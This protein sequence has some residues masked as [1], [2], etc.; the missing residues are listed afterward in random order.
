MRNNMPKCPIKR[1]RPPLELYN[2]LIDW[3]CGR[4]SVSKYFIAIGTAMVDPDALKP[5]TAKYLRELDERKFALLQ[6]K[7]ENR[8]A[9]R[10]EWRE[11]VKMKKLAAFGVEFL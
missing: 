9:D 5:K 8:I 7:V 6:W 2:T 4:V 1:P 3:I 10:A 11:Y